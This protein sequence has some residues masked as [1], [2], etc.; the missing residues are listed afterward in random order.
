VIPVVWV[1]NCEV[2]SASGTHTLPETWP[3][4]VDACE[5]ARSAGFRPI[6]AGDGE[7]DLSV[8]W[9]THFLTQAL[10]LP[11]DA[12]RLVLGELDWREERFRAAWALLDLA[13]RSGL[14]DEEALPLTLWDGLQRFNEGRSAFTLAYGPM[15]AGSRRVLGEAA[16]VFVAPRAGTGRLAGLPI[17]D[18]QGIG[19][20]ASSP[21]A[22]LAASLL[23]HLHR[24]AHRKRLWD[25][26][27]LFPGDRRWPGPGATA[28]PDY[29]RMWD[30]YAHG[31]SA[32][33]VPNLMPLDL[34]YDLAAGIGQDVLAG[35]LDGDTA[36]EEAV[37]RSRAWV[38][39]DPARTAVYREWA[40][41]AASAND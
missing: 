6:T 18:T 21:A 3:E 33:Y 4:L 19:I 39:G 37:R 9:V 40:L 14:L 16:V 11:A 38:E 27:R 17:L 41:E 20:S 22:R 35:R 28:D 12:V 30:W 32:P 15:L 2:L 7:G 23:A 26:V 24:P 36:G 5:R 29:G 31:P 25:D 1:A 8:W 34:H 13:R 10:D